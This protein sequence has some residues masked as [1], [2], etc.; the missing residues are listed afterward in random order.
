ME[1]ARTDPTA[2]VMADYLKQWSAH[3]KRIFIIEPHPTFGYNPAT[4]LAKQIAQGNPIDNFVIS[5][6]KF[7]KEIDPGWFKILAAM[8]TC[9]KCV[10]IEMRSAFCKEDKCLLYE[11]KTMLSLYCD[12]A[13]LSPHGTERM[14][15]V[16]NTHFNKALDELGL[17]S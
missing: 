17:N 7:K 3:V 8:E 9:P 13:H 1:Q 15:P 5:P 12:N 11:E 4:Q 10:P 16:L 6:N 14:V 2:L